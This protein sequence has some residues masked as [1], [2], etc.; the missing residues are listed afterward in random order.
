M[1][2]YKHS[3][4]WW[5]RCWTGRCA[6]SPGHFHALSMRDGAVAALVPSSPGHKTSHPLLAR[7]R[8]GDRSEW[9]SKALQPTTRCVRH[10]SSPFQRTPLEG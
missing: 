9:G 1:P 2:R 7:V 3:H 4:E 10:L 8:E 6:V 5:P